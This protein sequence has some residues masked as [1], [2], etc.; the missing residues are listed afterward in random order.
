MTGGGIYRS[1]DKSLFLSFEG[2]NNWL[3][4]G[5]FEKMLNNQT[6]LLA[7]FPAILFLLGGKMHSRPAGILAAALAIMQEMNGI[8]LMSDFPVIS[9]KVLLSE[10]FMQLWTGI[11]TL[12]GFIAFKGNKKLQTVLIIIFGGSLGLSSLFRLNTIVV[13]PFIV[14]VAF[15][16]YFRDKKRMAWFIGVFLAG[17]FISLSPWMVYNA[18]KFHNPIAFV[19]SKVGGVII[20]TRYEKIN[21]QAG[22]EENSS[23]VVLHHIP[24]SA[25]DT[26]LTDKIVNSQSFIN[27]S[28]PEITFA[29]FNNLIPAKSLINGILDISKIAR[30]VFR[31]F[32]NN[33]ISSFSILPTSIA[34]QDLFHGARVQKFWGTYDAASYEGI[35]P[36]LVALNLII[37]A[38]GISSVIKNRQIIGVLPI[39][40]FL[41][42][43]LSNGLAI[44]SGNRYTQPV[45]WVIYFYFAIGLVV[46]TKYIIDLA[47]NNERIAPITSEE[48]KQKNKTVGLIVAIS[49]ILAF[50]SAPLI[51]DSLPTDRYPKTTSDN[52]LSTIAKDNNIKGTSDSIDRFLGSFKLEK[53]I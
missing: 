44:S 5:S 51:A 35:N 45:S 33:I 21:T 28:N 20:D 3:V 2:L 34:P 29:G 15:F 40:V 26:L 39:A 12:T 17:I 43:H 19:R 53:L 14:I 8:Q 49:L 9:S 30:S 42:Y 31:H 10:P 25:S 1:I 16:Y 37:L 6:I 38:V 46:I 22:A 23:E 11:I 32:L 48:P 52:L 4:N 13:I 47:G 24:D 18:I 7:L 27:S 50:G 36:V 41:G